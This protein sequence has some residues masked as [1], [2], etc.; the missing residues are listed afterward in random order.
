MNDKKEKVSL[1]NI[2]WVFVQMGAVCFGGGYA[3]LPILERELVNKRGWTTK[4]NIIDYYAIGQCTP[5]VIAVNTSTFVGNE[6]G[7]IFGG[8]AGTLG[9]IT[10]SIVI[11]SLIA[12]L[13]QNFAHITVIQNAFTGIR[14][15]V[16]ALIVDATVKLWKS[17]IKDRL[18]V[19]I[20][21]IVV[22]VSAIF[23]I[24]PIFYVVISGATGYFAKKIGGNK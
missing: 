12:K 16:C 15:C 17:A 3:M 7:G 23:D 1:L 2:Y 6:I 10:P 22:V 24:S 18:G 14:I 11:I 21:L 5:G 19:V 20:F 4:E 13:L 8:I 9:F